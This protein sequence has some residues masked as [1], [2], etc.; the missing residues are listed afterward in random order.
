M[1]KAPGTWIVNDVTS[2]EVEELMTAFQAMTTVVKFANMSLNHGEIDVAQQNYIEAKVLF[3]KLGNERGV[4][5]V[6]NNL[7]SV[8]TL[9]AREFAKQA[10][11]ETDKAKADLLMEKADEK[12][13]D[14]V[15]N[16]RV[17]Y[18]DRG[19]GIA[20]SFFILIRVS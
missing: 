3:L 9:Q 11:A 19:V 5:I 16:Y 10:A 4:G 2:P 12:F 8:Y 1:L 13:Y 17:S 20:A 15:T 14:A 18:Q 6:H 7:G